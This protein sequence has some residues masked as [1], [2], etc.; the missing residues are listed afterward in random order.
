ME[1]V[2]VIRENLIIEIEKLIE[3]IKREYPEYVDLPEDLDL[4]NRIH[5]DDTG[6]IL[7]FFFLT[8]IWSL[9][10]DMVQC[11][12]NFA[13]AILFVLFYISIEIGRN[14]LVNLMSKLCF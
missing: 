4:E 2:G 6:T 1:N 13:H 12:I 8:F 10:L 9:Y 7:F 14:L 3:I 5:I 11:A